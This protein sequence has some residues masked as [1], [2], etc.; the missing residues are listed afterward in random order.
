MDLMR[1]AGK[2]SHKWSSRVVHHRKAHARNGC[3][4]GDCA[5]VKAHRMDLWWHQCITGS[6]NLGLTEGYIQR[7]HNASTSIRIE[8][9]KPCLNAACCAQDKLIISHQI[10]KF[11]LDMFSRRAALSFHFHLYCHQHW[12]RRNCKSGVWC[13]TGLALLY[14]VT[15]ISK[16]L[17]V[18]VAMCFNTVVCRAVLFEVWCHVLGR[19]WKCHISPFKLTRAVRSITSLL[20]DHGCH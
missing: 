3:D 15:D 17:S 11:C 19:E 14:R 13:L 20:T 7:T 1:A 18:R 8:N 16:G 10:I 2:L 12:K 6:S 5:M 4:C 9:R